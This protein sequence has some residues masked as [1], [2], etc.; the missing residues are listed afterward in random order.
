M[1]RQIA[2]SIAIAL[3]AFS[4]AAIV[5]AQVPG[6]EEPV[7]IQGT[8][9]MRVRKLP[10]VD[11]VDPKVD[12]IKLDHV[13]QGAISQAR[14]L[15]EGQAQEQPVQAL[16]QPAQLPEVAA[17][18]M[19]LS[20]TTIQAMDP[21]NI[22]AAKQH[23]AA[24]T[25]ELSSAAQLDVGV[26]LAADWSA[27]NKA[28]GT[29]PRPAYEPNNQSNNQSMG[30]PTPQRAQPQQYGNTLQDKLNGLR[31]ALLGSDQPQPAHGTYQQRRTTAQPPQ[32]RSNPNGGNVPHSNGN[33]VPR[34]AMSNPPRSAMGNAPLGRPVTNAPVEQQE[35][36]SMVPVVR[37]TAPEPPGVPRMTSRASRPG[38]PTLA[39]SG[40]TSSANKAHDPT[41]LESSRQRRA[42]ETLDEQEA[43]TT[44]ESDSVDVNAAMK[45]ARGSSVVA[46]G[47]IT[48]AVP[49]LAE[50]PTAAN[51]PVVAQEPTNTATLGSVGTDSS[52]APIG[53]LAKRA[54]TPKD[55]NVLMSVSGPQLTAQAVGPRRIVIS[56]NAEFQVTVSN[57]GTVEAND[58]VVSVQLPNWVDVTS[59]APTRGSADLLTAE[60]KDQ[61]L[62]WR[63][64]RLDANS[65]EVLKIN[66]VPRR[67]QPLDMS[68][69]W[70]YAQTAT[71]ALVEVEEPMLQ[72]VISGPSEAVYGQTKLY[73][74][75]LSNPGTGDAHNVVL[76][77]LPL[78]GKQESPA[79][80]KVGVLAHGETKTIQVEL[81]AGKAGVL[82]VKANASADGGL[83]AEATKEVL[84]RR[85][86]LVIEVV[87]PEAEYAGNPANFLVRV[88]NDGNAPAEDVTVNAVLPEGAEYVNSSNDGRYEQ[89]QGR[90]RWDIGSLAAGEMREYQLSSKLHVPGENRLHT[91]VQDKSDLNA[92][93]DVQTA[94]I[95][96][97]DLKLVVT[98]PK[99][100]VPVGE[101][102]VYELTI[103]NRGT[104][105]AEAIEAVIF[106]SEGV[107]PINVEGADHEIGSGQVVFKTIPQIAANGELVLKVTSRADRPGNH[108][109]RAEILCR[110][111][112]T[113]L[114]AEETTHFYGKELTAEASQ[115][116]G[117][118]ATR[119]TP[120]VQRLPGNT[121]HSPSPLPPAQIEKK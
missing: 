43:E 51:E 34:S 16:E 91:A 60:Q 19:E 108:V 90:V 95:G 117:R 45:P 39:G 18:P 7:A 25:K 5:V 82:L 75:T 73:N 89:K 66:L 107:E 13:G 22:E 6:G 30:N 29:F 106:F 44:G 49:Q 38:T 110:S 11:G 50:E 4:V 113:K 83:T 46:S 59:T 112:G 97:A 70:T 48:P 94:V 119:P 115:P 57:S 114:A 20:H 118:T 102:A 40:S 23:A 1:L 36:E 111:I 14:L 35:A 104:I 15:A 31:D 63:I 61:P 21:A 26:V 64:A 2:A 56:Q 116:V 121:G 37:S 41:S 65:S 27:T 105:A 76:S 32:V 33:N 71:N 109:F 52:A 88:I 55:D 9:E 54:T 77:L 85:A 42:L 79:S 80:T 86:N 81:S 84:V 93:A 74:L 8:S 10:P 99:G 17:R 69:R 67:S 68:V 47:P 72:M 3:V 12:V 96:R 92:V 100:P 98:D 58:V 120:A 87:A 78:E 28:R 103:H 24:Q 101:A 62:L 53:P